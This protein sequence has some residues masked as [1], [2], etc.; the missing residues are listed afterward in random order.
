MK[1][2]LSRKLV[3][4]MLLLVAASL[5][6]Y[7]CK[8][9]LKS[10][11]DLSSE[12]TANV[13]LK[14]DTK[15]LTEVSLKAGISAITVTNEDNRTIYKPKSYNRVVLNGSPIRLD[16]MSFVLENNYL[17]IQGNPE[18]SVSIA[19]NKKVYIVSPNYVGF[20]ENIKSYK[21]LDS[22]AAALILVLGEITTFTADQKKEAYIQPDGVLTISLPSTSISNPSKGSLA[23]RDGDPGHG[24][25]ACGSNYAVTVGVSRSEV[26]SSLAQDLANTSMYSGCSRVGSIDISCLFGSDHGCV[27]TQAFYC[28]CT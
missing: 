11:E 6:F 21:D 1:K 10:D 23:V 27:G 16:S 8:K 20:L 3:S 18:Y 7:A 13:V 5:T 4:S 9:E 19:K 14:T 25:I 2:R 28:P 26:A 12:L 15:L 22:K 17:H 24:A